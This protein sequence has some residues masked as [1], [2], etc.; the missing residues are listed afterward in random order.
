MRRQFTHFLGHC[1]SISDMTNPLHAVAINVAE[2]TKINKQ[3][4]PKFVAPS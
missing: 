4:G 2:E 3:P 1:N